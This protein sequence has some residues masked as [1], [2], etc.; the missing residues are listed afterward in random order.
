MLLKE[1]SIFKIDYKGLR[2]GGGY[3]I[4]KLKTELIWAKRD[5]MKKKQKLKRRRFILIIGDKT[6]LGK[7]PQASEI[8]KGVNFVTRDFKL[9]QSLLGL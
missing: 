1:R 7:Y 3:T 2:V 6:L 9:Q 8:A 4:K 5:P